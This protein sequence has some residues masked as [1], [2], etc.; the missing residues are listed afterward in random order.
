ML[1]PEEINDIHCQ[2]KQ[3]PTSSFTNKRKR[4]LRHE[5][6]KVLKEHEYASTYSPFEPTGYEIIFVNRRTSIDTLITL[7]T[8][9]KQTNI[10]TLDTESIIRRFQSNVPALIQLQLCAEP[11]SIVI[12]I[13]VH[14]LP[15]QNKKEFQLI[16]NLFNSLFVEE[17]KILIWG[18]IKELEQFTQFNLFNLQQIYLSTN[19]NIQHE[20][21]LYWK[22]VYPHHENS[23]QKCQCRSCFGIDHD[24]PLALQDAVAFELGQ[25]LDK[26]LTC[27]SFNIG[28][29]PQLKR[30]NPR[31]FQYRQSLWMYAANDCNAIYRI[32]IHSNIINDQYSEA[33]PVNQV[34]NGI[35]IEEITNEFNDGGIADEINDEITLDE[36]GQAIIVGESFSIINSTNKSTTTSTRIYN[37]PPAIEQISSDDEE[38]MDPAPKRKQL[39]KPTERNEPVLPNDDR[40]L[41]TNNN[42]QVNPGPSS[43]NNTEEV[44]PDPSSINDTE[45]TNPPATYSKYK[46]P[47]S[48][49]ERKKIHNKSRSKHQRVK[50]YTREIILYNI[51]KR[52]PVKM[53]K[54]ML[55][56]NGV[57]ITQVNPVRSRR[58]GQITLYVGLKEPVQM[59]KYEEIKE[60][61][62]YENYR[63]LFPHKFKKKEENQH[64]R[65]YRPSTHAYEYNRRVYR[66]PSHEYEHNRRVYRTSSHA[67]EH[68]RRKYR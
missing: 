47:L 11:S 6:N 30:L 21:K 57:S 35:L 42:D 59:K 27:Q 53:I 2:L 7:D 43:M 32:I 56:E 28:L 3:I 10:F 38:P 4:E 65:A 39:N 1:S 24:G 18:E 41:Q 12:I 62:T 66:T 23:K 45:Q 26:R 58:T 13:E 64:R 31:E 46:N 51:E 29:D 19:R 40:P 20:F 63:R 8:K 48:E 16:Q 44:H 14:H 17:N 55:K 50:A 15:E 54:Q 34:N 33:P 25:W 67:Y 9:I 52:F 49:I 61:F 60:L 5:L 22:K 36:K 37:E 68:D